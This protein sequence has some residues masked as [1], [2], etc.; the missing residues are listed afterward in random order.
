MDLITINEWGFFST[1]NN[2]MFN[3]YVRLA[4]GH[5]DLTINTQDL[6]GFTGNLIFNG[7]VE[8]KIYRKTQYLINR[9]NRRFPVKI[10]P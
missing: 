2:T 9:E 5:G 3:S 6:R 10:L 8:G 1:M 7:L 4:E